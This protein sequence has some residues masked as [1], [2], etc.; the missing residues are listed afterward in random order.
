[1]HILHFFCRLIATFNPPDRA[2]PKGRSL[3]M[4]QERERPHEGEAVED[5]YSIPRKFAYKDKVEAV[6]IKD[7]KVSVTW[8]D[9]SGWSG[10]W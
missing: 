3:L 7:K 10:L 8:R 2:V 9:G 5:H 4:A 1:M 6:V